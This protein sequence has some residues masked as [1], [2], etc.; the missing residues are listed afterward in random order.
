RR[1]RCSTTEELLAQAAEARRELAA[2][3]GGADL[4][5]AAAQA[6][7]EAEERVEA[8][9]AE[10]RAAREGARTPFA[11]AVAAE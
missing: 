7:A 5:A 2:L 3:E 8:L 11:D 4:V 1:Y 6:L 10:L 9:T